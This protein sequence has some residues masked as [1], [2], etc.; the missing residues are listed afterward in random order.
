LTARDIITTEARM[1][2]TRYGDVEYAQH[3]F[4]SCNFFGS[5]WFLLR[6]WIGSLPVDPQHL[7]DHP[8][9]FIHSSGGSRAQRS[10]LQVIWLLC[11]WVIWN[12]RNHRLFKDLE[13]SLS[14]LLDKIKIHSIESRL[15]DHFS[16]V[17]NS[18]TSRINLI[19]F[20]SILIQ[21][22]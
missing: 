22:Y 14:Q 6:S 7:I 1:C 17:P 4:V 13:K 9:Q 18:L 15:D 10:F 2:V 3:L 20:H 11:V 21:F 12:N 16:K 19:L 5:L 8:H